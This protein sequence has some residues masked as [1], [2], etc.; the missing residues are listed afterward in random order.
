MNCKCGME[1]KSGDISCVR[2]GNLDMTKDESLQAE[3]EY[4][5]QTIQDLRDA[6]AES[7]SQRAN[8]H[9]MYEDEYDRAEGYKKALQKLDDIIFEPAYCWEQSQFVKRIVQKALRSG[10]E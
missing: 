3:R 8:W 10:E 7:Q 9:S 6:L 1:Y 5:L 4:L 2:C